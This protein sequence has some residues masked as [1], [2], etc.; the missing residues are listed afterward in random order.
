MGVLAIATA[1]FTTRKLGERAN[2]LCSRG[3]D[4][5][6]LHVAFLRI[7]ADRY[8]EQVYRAATPSILLTNKAGAA[9][10]VEQ[11]VRRS[12][13]KKLASA[14]GRSLLGSEPKR[15]VRRHHQR[16]S[17]PM[18]RSVLAHLGKDGF[19]RYRDGYE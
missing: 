4:G 9:A 11:T 5:R 15:R 13:H 17:T 10:P 2:H 19:Q 7:Y 8:N 18:C 6:F 3:F 16:R 1:K 14:N 12:G